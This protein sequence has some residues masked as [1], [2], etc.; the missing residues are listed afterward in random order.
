MSNDTLFG[1]SVLA[2]VLPHISYTPDLISRLYKKHECTVEVI[3]ISPS[4]AANRLKL[5]YITPEL[6]LCMCKASD[7]LFGI[8]IT[9]NALPAD[10]AFVRSFYDEFRRCAV[11]V[12]SSD[13]FDAVPDGT[14]IPEWPLIQFRRVEI[15]QEPEGFGVPL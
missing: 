14:E 8:E 13:S 10:A 3:E 11:F 7:G 12:L 5:L 1:R 4:V 9:E 15:S 2:D 6:I